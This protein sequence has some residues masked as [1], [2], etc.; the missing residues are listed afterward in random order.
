MERALSPALGRDGRR[1]IDVWSDIVG[2]SDFN[3]GKVDHVSGIQA[4]SD[5]LTITLAAPAPD[6]LGRMALSYSCPVPLGT[7]PVPSLDPTTPVPSSGPYFLASHAGGEYAILNRNPNYGGARHGE[8]DSIVLR[9]GLAE[10]ETATWADDGRASMAIGDPVL[11]AGTDLAHEWGPDGPHGATGDQRWYEIAY[12]GSDYLLLNPN[13][14]LTGDETVRQAIAVALDRTAAA[15]SFFEPGGTTLLDEALHIRDEPVANLVG[16]NADA[17]RA[18]LAGRTGT[19]RFAI[20]A[21][22]DQCVDSANA[23]KSNLAAI[24][25]TVDVVEEDDPTGAAGIAKNKIDIIA[26]YSQAPF[27]DAATVVNLVITTAPQDW[28]EATQLSAADALIQLAGQARDEQAATL[29]QALTT[30]ATVIPYGVPA[31]GV[32]FGTSVGCRTISP[33]LMNVDLVALCPQPA[34]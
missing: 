10:G 4:D 15:Q 30:S 33:G 11:Q 1:A 27:P 25:L 17:A 13:G 8:Y 28:F 12:P 23:I 20:P 3:E 14:A 7:P 32:Y 18:L 29:A 34:N 16:P 26:N 22:C 2:A 31:D 19:V 24:G 9:F 21:N 6:F 5:K